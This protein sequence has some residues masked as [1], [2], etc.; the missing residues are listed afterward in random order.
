METGATVILRILAALTYKCEILQDDIESHP[1]PRQPVAYTASGRMAL[2]NECYGDLFLFSSIVDDD[3]IP[4]RQA[5]LDGVL[6]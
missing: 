6:S 3:R 1:Q 5:P 4:T 2:F